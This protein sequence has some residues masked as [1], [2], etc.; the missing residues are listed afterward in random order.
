MSRQTGANAWASQSERGHYWPMKLLYWLYRFGGRWLMVPPVALVVLYFFLTRPSTRRHSARYLARVTGRPAGLWQVWLHHWA[1]GRSLID[2]L[3]AWMDRIQRTDVYFPG[4]QLL[5]ELQEQKRG[6]VLLGAHF[7]NLEMCRAVVENDGSIKLNVILHKGNKEKFNRLVRNVS[8]KAEVR[9]IYVTDVNPAT[10]MLLKEKLDQGEFLIVLADRLPPVPATR[11]LHAPF[12]GDEAE[13]PAGP[14]WLALMLGAPV[15]FM[16]GFSAGSG[17]QAV[18]E[19]LYDGGHVP[20][21]EREVICAQ[22]L[23]DYIGKLET[24][25][26]R[27]PYQWFN[28]FDFWGDEQAPDRNNKQE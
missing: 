17:Y 6:A 7:G 19:P 8:D 12:L 28:F 9:L 18:M 25:C 10:A 20:R 4:H 16:A 13:F 22:L 24:Y 26:R 3:G 27:Y 14:F 23:A 11:S 2:R 5:L 15:Y 1:F 21:R